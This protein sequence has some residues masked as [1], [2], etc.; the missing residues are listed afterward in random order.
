MCELVYRFSHPFH[1]L[2]PYLS[3]R[4]CPPLEASLSAFYATNIVLCSA[5]DEPRG[6]KDE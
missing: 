3:G 4:R 6:M 1:L 2:S 5:L